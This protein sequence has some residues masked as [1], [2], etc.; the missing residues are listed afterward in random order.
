MKARKNG[1]QTSGSICNNNIN[2]VVKKWGEIVHP[3]TH[4]T[5]NMIMWYS[6]HPLLEFSN[7]VADLFLHCFLTLKVTLNP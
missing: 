4:L 5:I 1:N 7:G 3:L 2:L 6:C